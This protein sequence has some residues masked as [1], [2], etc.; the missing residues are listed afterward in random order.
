MRV[1]LRNAVAELKHLHLFRF[2]SGSRALGFWHS[3]ACISPTAR[4]IEDAREQV[5]EK[6]NYCTADTLRYGQPKPIPKPCTMIM[7]IMTSNAIVGSR[8]YLRAFNKPYMA[9]WQ[10]HLAPPAFDSRLPSLASNIQVLSK[11]TLKYIP[12]YV[13][14]LPPSVANFNWFSLENR[15]LVQLNH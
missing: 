10:H 8:H 4:K 6:G 9:T 2:Q 12:Q 7:L 1:N 5:W 3:T 15:E 13:A 14:E 11:C